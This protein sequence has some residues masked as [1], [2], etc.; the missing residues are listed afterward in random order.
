MKKSVFISTTALT[1]VALA[2]SIVSPAL[3]WH[4][5]GKIVKQVTNVTAGTAKSDANNASS[6]VAAKPGDILTYTITISNPAKPA[7]KQYNDLAFVVLKDSLPAGVELVKDPSIRTINENLGTIVPGKSVTKEL[8]VKV[9]ATKNG[10]I[11]NKACFEGDSVVKDA[12]RKG[13]DTAN[14]KVTVPP[15]PVA[16]VETPKTPQTPAPQ[17]VEPAGK[18]AVEA[19]AELPKTGPASVLA[20]AGLATIAGYLGNLARLRFARGY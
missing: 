18:G 20:A 12:P 8:T 14:V 2:T 9:T 11:E 16:P 4:P 6:A 17:P 10:V 3:A 13:C 5:E 1:G 19:P 15:A 7:E